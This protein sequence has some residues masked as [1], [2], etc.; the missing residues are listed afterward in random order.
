MKNSIRS[1]N[2]PDPAVDLL[3]S[4][5]EQ[6]WCAEPTAVGVVERLVRLIKSRADTGLMESVFKKKSDCLLNCGRSEFRTASPLIGK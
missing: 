5:V 3:A 6:S 2:T 1:F 4:L